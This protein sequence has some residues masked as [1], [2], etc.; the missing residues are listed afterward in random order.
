MNRAEAK[1]TAGRLTHAVKRP[2]PAERVDSDDVVAFM[3]LRRFTL[4]YDNCL[5]SCTAN[6]L[7]RF[8]STGDIACLGIQCHR[9]LVLTRRL[10][11]EILTFEVEHPL[12]H[13]FPLHNHGR[14]ITYIPAATEGSNFTV[15]FGTQQK[16]A[17][18]A[19]EDRNQSL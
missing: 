19:S 1:Q 6:L 9:G 14:S 11:T 10:F 16:K 7:A 2:L 5:H 15:A 13:S 12:P 17:G 3:G 4:W 8:S 18:A